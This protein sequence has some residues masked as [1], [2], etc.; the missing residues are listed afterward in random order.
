[1][2][3]CPIMILGFRSPVCLDP[4][5]FGHPLARTDVRHWRIV[6]LHGCERPGKFLVRGIEFQKL[7]NMSN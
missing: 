5:G 4:D 6:D 3:D 7:R 2:D 1:M